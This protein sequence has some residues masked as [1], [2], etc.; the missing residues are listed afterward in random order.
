MLAA[1][2]NGLLTAYNYEHPH[3]VGLFLFSLVSRLTRKRVIVAVLVAIAVNE[4][5]YREVLGAT[6]GMKADKASG[7]SF[8]QWLRSRG[9]DGIKLTIGDK[10]MEIWRQRAKCTRTP[11]TPALHRP[12]LTEHLL[13]CAPFQDENGSR[14]A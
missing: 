7:V 1:R 12:L 11:S 4:G 10:C 6:E 2:R 3:Q 13:R 14:D 5:G 9:L 8:F